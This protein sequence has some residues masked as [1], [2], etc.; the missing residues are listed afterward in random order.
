MVKLGFTTF[1]PKFFIRVHIYIQLYYLTVIRLTALQSHVHNLVYG[2]QYISVGAIV[3]TISVWK[4][5]VC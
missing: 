3:V 2:Y 4:F 1:F 5:D